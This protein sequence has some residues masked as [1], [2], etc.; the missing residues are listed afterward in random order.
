MLAKE[1]TGGAMT[2][3]RKIGNCLGALI[4]VL[5]V[6]VLSPAQAQQ[7]TPAQTDAVRQSCRSDFMA[8]CTGV[9]PGTREALQCLQHNVAKLSPS[10]KTAVRATMPAPPPAAAAPAPPPP[11]VA[12]APSPPPAAAGP[13]PAVAPLKV[14]AFIMPQRRIVITTICS[15]DAPKLCPGMPPIGP[16]LLNCLAAHASALS[17]QCYD[18]IGRVSEN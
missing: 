17:K 5:V 8:D 2:M 1:A 11:A 12:T 16:G 3:Q 9:Q 15:G 10:C 4:G 18:A 13:A 7:P 14:R 6:S